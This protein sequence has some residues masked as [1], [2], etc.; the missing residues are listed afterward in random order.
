MNIKGRQPVLLLL[1][2]GF[3]KAFVSAGAE[4]GTS[5]VR[6]SHWLEKYSPSLPP[7]PP[8]TTRPATVAKRRN[9]S[10][11]ASDPDPD[12]LKRKIDWAR[13]R[14]AVFGPE[15]MVDVI[16]TGVATKVVV[17][18]GYVLMGKSAH[19]VHRT[20][21]GGK[22]RSSHADSRQAIKSAVA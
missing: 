15:N 11:A 19:S 16:T 18:T 7:P 22:L 13:M 2:L 5:V 20:G 6:S 1:L 21:N 4:E 10:A 17:I 8:W 3:G 14:E 12:P 9:G